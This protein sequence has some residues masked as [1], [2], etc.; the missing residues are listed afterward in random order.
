M[1]LTGEQVG[2]LED[3]SGE[4]EK[5]LLAL[6]EQI[7]AYFETQVLGCSLGV[8]IS[9]EA[10]QKLVAVKCQH[11]GA[12]KARQLFQNELQKIRKAAR[13]RRMAASNAAPVKGKQQ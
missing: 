1:S 10:Q 2:D 12:L 7:E 5:A 3:L 8:G 4:Q 11:E 9:P 13:D 6:F